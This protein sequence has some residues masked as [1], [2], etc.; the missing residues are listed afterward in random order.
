MTRKDQDLVLDT[1]GLCG[2]DWE[3]RSD[4]SVR[5]CSSLDAL[6][7]SAR[8]L[9]PAGSEVLERMPWLLLV[10]W[11]WS[12]RCG[13]GRSARLLRQLQGHTGTGH[14]SG[15]SAVTHAVESTCSPLWPVISLTVHP[16]PQLRR[17]G[18]HLGHHCYLTLSLLIYARFW[19]FLLKKSSLV[20]DI[21]ICLAV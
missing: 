9:L 20:L 1:L 2:A 3:K 14:Q 15:D 6:L 16:G 5:A 18:H 17:D 7:S 10:Q 4:V 8:P 21:L 13:S 19:A 11:C 12:G